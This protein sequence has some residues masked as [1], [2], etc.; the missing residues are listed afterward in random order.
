MSASACPSDSELRGFHAG[1]QSADGRARIASHLHDCPACDAKVVGFE[2]PTAAIRNGAS[3]APP[4]QPTWRAGRPHSD[5]FHASPW[6]SL[7]DYEILEQLGSGAAGVVYRARHRGLNRLVALKCIRVERLDGARVRREAEAVA[8]LQHPNIVQIYEAFERAGEQYL[9]LELVSGGSL[10]QRL[11]GKPQP[12]LPSALLL[13]T[14]ARAIGYAHERGVVHRDLKPGNILLQIAQDE[15]PQSAIC[16][17]QS[18]IPKITDFGIA[19]RLDLTL[20]TVTVRGLVVGTPP[21]MAPE[22]ARGDNEDVGPAVDIYALGVLLY[23]MLTGRPPFQGANAFETLRQV[24]SDEPVAP[25]RLCPQVPRDLETICLKCLAKE[26]AQ[27][28]ATAQA[29]ADDVQRFLDGK[30]IEARPTSRWERCAKAVRRHPLVTG[31]SCIIVLT[32]LI[33]LGLVSWEW[34]QAEEA[35]ADADTKSRLEATA[36][37]AADQARRDAEQRQARLALDKGLA[38]CE[39]GEVGQGLVWLVH[40]LER[41]VQAGDAGLERAARINLASWHEQLCRPALTVTLPGPA[42]SVAYSPDGRLLAVGLRSGAAYL[43]DAETGA[44]RGPCLENWD[45]FPP[46]SRNTYALAFQP[47]HGRVLAIGGGDGRAR[48]WPLTPGPAG[49][50]HPLVHQEIPLLNLVGDFNVW[51]LAYSKDGKY[52]ATGYEDGKARLWDTASRRELVQLDHG[53]GP[54]LA[55]AFTRDGFLLTGARHGGLRLWSIPDG[56]PVRCA[57]RQPLGPD[58]SEDA[59]FLVAPPESVFALALSPDG[60]EV[61][62]GTDSAV[63][64]YSLVDG[65]QH[66]VP[67]LHPARVVAVDFNPDGQSFLSA[68]NHG[69]IRI[70]DAASHLPMCSVI[71][72]DSDLRGAVRYRPGGRQ[73]AV[74]GWDGVLRCWHVPPRLSVGPALFQSYEVRDAGFSTTGRKI[75][76]ATVAGVQWWDPERGEQ[77]GGVWRHTESGLQSAALSPD[78]RWAFISSYKGKETDQLWNV[79]L[80][81]PHAALH[82]E[83]YH[84]A[85]AVFSPSGDLLL[86]LVDD[87]ET[88]RTGVTWWKL[89]ARKPTWWR[90]GPRLPR[91]VCAAFHPDG[92]LIAFG[93]NDG[94]VQ[95]WD[96]PGGCLTPTSLHHPGPVSALAFSCDG[97]LLAVAG[98]TGNLRV[99]DT[100]RWQP[101]GPAFGHGDTVHSVAFGADHRALLT[102]S[103]DSTARFWDAATGVA[104]GAPL[105]HRAAVYRAAYSP[106]GAVVLTASRDMTARRW[107]V[108]AAPLVGEPALLTTW[109]EALTGLAL[110]EGGTIGALDP[111]A[112]RARRDRIAAADLPR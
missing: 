71:R 29:L 91:T 35:R 110:E 3:E 44:P 81:R 46:R 40:G 27:R 12:P 103:F 38:L 63:R 84:P 42:R 13:Q 33:G 55:V 85:R 73:L 64:V 9:A 58:E 97:T 52:L 61:V 86:T 10:E 37:Q 65:K 16:N 102:A 93:G 7:P 111:G 88:V 20:G 87:L 101:L 51:D 112:V 18:A 105:R 59:S 100:T 72:H 2:Q 11:A 62:V 57:G 26:P 74:A 70:W 94:L 92:Q 6:P 30:P 39:Q 98:R 28:Y 36:R 107:R 67:L 48:L 60:A 31:L 77:L 4:P 69:H 14:L 23:E 54:V 25:S 106:D 66:N 80:G 56:K 90:E 43:Y 22:Q 41:A 79:A 68:D 99:W 47:P 109:V 5:T 8:H 17:L 83:G 21:Y 15:V 53:R 75:F 19:K 78:G 1:E 49:P 50:P 24:I 108:P 45:V 76:T 95:F 104:L 82:A 34:Y 89:G 96:V 32:L